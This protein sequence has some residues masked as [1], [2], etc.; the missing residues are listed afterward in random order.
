LPWP[1]R[2]HFS[3]FLRR[4]W[5]PGLLLRGKSGLSGSISR[6]FTYDSGLV[7]KLQTIN[8]KLQTTNYIYIYIYIHK[9]YTLEFVVY[10]L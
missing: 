7:H 6:V 9:A 5:S 10:S 1:G 2:L 8:Y 3:V 4:M